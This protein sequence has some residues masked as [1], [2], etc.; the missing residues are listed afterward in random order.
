MQPP[1]PEMSAPGPGAS[2]PKGNAHSFGQNFV[3]TQ[4]AGIE[5]QTQPMGDSSSCTDQAEQPILPPV[6]RQNSPRPQGTVPPCTYQAEIPNFTAFHFP[7][8]IIFEATLSSTQGSCLLGRPQGTDHMGCLEN[9]TPIGLALLIFG[10]V[11][12]KRAS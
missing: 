11:L 6:T 10:A 7:L 2:T 4:L 3:G 9:R 1:L 12:L 8:V 5:K